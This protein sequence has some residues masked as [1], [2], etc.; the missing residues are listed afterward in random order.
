MA[1]AGEITRIAEEAYTPYVERMAGRRPAPMDLDYAAVVVEAEAWVAEA[2]GAVIGFLVL[3][4]DGDALLLDGV[5][6][7]PSHQG[8]GAGR[9]LLTLAEEQA[10][11]GGFVRVSLY[12][13]EAMVESQA[14]YER[15]GY[16]ETHR[17]AEHGFARVFYEKQ[18]TGG[19]APDPRT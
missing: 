4:A 19:T 16:V 3:V 14:L 8:H 2:D 13:N 10:R 9:A 12:T 1:D 18:L 5:A 7:G 6:V 11:R 15:I 17:A